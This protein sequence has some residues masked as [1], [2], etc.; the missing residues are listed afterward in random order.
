MAQTSRQRASFEWQVGIKEQAKGINL[1]GSPNV[2][3]EVVKLTLARCPESSQRVNGKE[4]SM[5]CDQE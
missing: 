5:S 2:N 3:C 1:E 4:W